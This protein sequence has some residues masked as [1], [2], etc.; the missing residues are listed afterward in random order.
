MHLVCCE[1]DALAWIF[2]KVE[3]HGGLKQ[4]PLRKT[5]FWLVVLTRF[6]AHLTFER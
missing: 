2:H 1:N 6:F 5:Q 3:G 4:P